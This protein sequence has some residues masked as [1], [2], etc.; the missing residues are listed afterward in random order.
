[1]HAPN[2]NRFVAPKIEMP[3]NIPIKRVRFTACLYT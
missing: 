2:L 3:T 1:M